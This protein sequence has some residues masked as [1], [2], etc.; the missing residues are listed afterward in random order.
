[1][2]TWIVAFYLL[3][4]VA[5]G[6]ALAKRVEQ[7]SDFLVAG[8]KL[9]LLLTTATLAAVQLGAGV[10][11]GGAELGAQHGVWPGAWYGI[12]CGGGLIFA[13]LLVARR[14]RQVRGFVPLDFFAKRYGEHKG[15]RLWAWLTNIP[16]LLGVFTAQ[17]MAA[18]SICSIF[19]L[20]YAQGVVLC[21]TAI[22]LYSIASGMWGVVVTDLVQL[23]IIVLGIPLVA[24]TAHFALASGSS[25]S[26]GSLLATPFI[27][28]GMGQKAIFIILP[29]LFSIAISY[30]AFVRY[31][32]AKSASVARWGCILAGIVVIVIGACAGLTGAAGKLL[33]PQ[34]DNGAAPDDQRNPLPLVGRHRRLGPARRSDVQRQLSTDFNFRYDHS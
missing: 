14:L 21:G 33:F 19:G 25:V 20:S 2:L 5:I 15:V 1:M 12:G 4:M 10:I 18:G 17:L 7:T 13:G 28:A 24:W 31:Q 9:G 23:T 34:A 26:F 29:F 32:S 11:L 16:S 22:G 27:P 30:D 6:V 8:R 3:A